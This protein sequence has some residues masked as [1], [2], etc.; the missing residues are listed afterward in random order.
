[1][2]YPT[3]NTTTTAALLLTTKQNI[4]EVTPR[5]LA[6][7][8]RQQLKQNKIANNYS[9]ISNKSK[10]T[11]SITAA[12]TNTSSSSN[13]SNGNNIVTYSEKAKSTA[14]EVKTTQAIIKKIIKKNII[15]RKQR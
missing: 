1:M 5:I 9:S 10:L 4:I 6:A 14:V 15:I 8:S 2:F 11:T 12:N 3:T 7:V 13:K